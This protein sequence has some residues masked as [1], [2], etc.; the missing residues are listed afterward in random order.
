M[1][2]SA[3]SWKR[4]RYGFALFWFLSLL[5]SWTV[6]RVVLF[7]AFRPG[8]LPAGEV[9]RA[10]LGGFQRDAFAALAETIPLL[11]WMLLVGDRTFLQARWH[12]F[13]FLG[14]CLV[15]AYGQIFLLFVEF[16]FFD[17]FKSRFNTVAVDYL[18]YPKEVFVNIWESYHVGFIFAL[19]L[20]LSSRHDG[21]LR[22]RPHDGLPLP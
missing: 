21:P 19:C 6:L 18:L 22:H 7:F 4:S 10:F 9:V 13:L 8:G 11:F 17:E 5:A 14:G 15:F 3:L 20:A 12:R 16:F 1:N 2:N